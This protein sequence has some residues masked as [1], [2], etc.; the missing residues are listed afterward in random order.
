MEVYIGTIMP[1]PISWAPTGWHLCDGTILQIVQN[2]AL[3][4]LIG[5]MYGGDGRTTF[6]LPDLRCRIPL[7]MN[8]GATIP[9][10]TTQKLGTA[11]GA[12]NAALTVANMPAHTHTATFTPASGGGTLQASAAPA[13]SKTPSGNYLADATD[14]TGSGSTFENY[15]TPAAAGTLGNLAGLSVTGAGTVTN[16]S[17][18][19]GQA[20]AT[21]PPFA[22]LN[23]I[24]AINGYYPVRE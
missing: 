11:S 12:E 18:G 8:N 21:M 3:F 23:F 2:Q 16:A 4:T 14:T 6:A 7:A 9:N 20:A 13:N 22:V 19:G 1:W 10:L 24:I 15:V 5:N 17:T